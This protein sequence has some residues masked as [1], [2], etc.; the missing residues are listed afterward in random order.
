MFLILVFLNLVVVDNSSGN[1]RIELET[2]STDRYANYVSGNSSSV[3]S[4]LYT[5]QSGDFSTDLAYKS[6]SSLSLNGGTIK[7]SSGND[8]TLTLP[9][10]ASSN[11]LS[12]WPSVDA[13]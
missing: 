2:G 11:S 9:S 4:F 10:P 5:I 8:A 12:S 7:D 3:L 13:P 1:P 6:T